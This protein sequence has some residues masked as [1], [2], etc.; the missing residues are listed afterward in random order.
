MQLHSL[1]L[2]SE[3]HRD[4]GHRRYCCRATDAWF[5][6]MH[7]DGASWSDA[8]CIDAD[9]AFQQMIAAATS[10]SEDAAASTVSGAL[11]QILKI[12]NVTSNTH[13]GEFPGPMCSPLCTK[14]I[15]R[16]RQHAY[17]VTEKSDGIRVVVVSL[18]V[19]DFPQ[20]ECEE[21]EEG[22]W[23]FSHLAAV[24]ALE[25][26]RQDLWAGTHDKGTSSSAVMVMLLG[27]QVTL[28]SATTSVEDSQLDETY[29]VIA[30]VEG[31][32]SVA[33]VVRRR[34][35]G[36][37]FAY[38]VDRS[39]NAAYLFLDNHTSTGYQT[40]VLD[41][42]LMC[43]RSP[44]ATHKVVH[45]DVT[46]ATDARL[47]LGAFDLFCF[48]PS[49][50]GQE[51]KLTDSTMM[52]RYEFLKRVIA[53]CAVAPSPKDEGT[54]CLEGRVTWYAKPMWRVEDIG[55]CLSKLSY[56][57]EH[58][59]FLFDGPYGQTENDGLIFTPD[60]FPI[61]V[62]SSSVQLK[63]KWRHLLS[64]DWL[65]SAS[66]KLPD[67]YTVSLFFM[68]K[69]YGHRED[70]IG[71]WRL[72]KPMCI[73]NPRG[74][75]IP[76]DAAVVAECAYD[77]A[78]QQWYIQRLR[79]D[80]RGANSIMTAIS[81]YESLVE[82]ISLPRLLR[83]LQAEVDVGQKEGAAARLAA[84]LEE[85]VLADVSTGAPSQHTLSDSGPHAVDVAQAGKCVTASMTLR[86]IRESRGNSELYLT[87]YTNNT[88][89]AVKF[90][91]PFPLRKIKDCVGLGYDPATAATSVP[92]LE[93]ALYIQLGNA[94]G[95]YAWSD[96]VVDA[97]YNGET[98]CWEL[99]HLSPRGNNKEALFDNVIE[100]LDWLLRHSGSAELE[101]LLQ[102]KRDKPLVVATVH[103]SE[104][105][106]QTSRHY[107]AV[108]KEL[109]H[110]ERSDLRR[111]NN[112]VKSLL[113]TTSAAAVRKTLK[114]PAKLHTVD[115]CCGRGGDLLK[116]QHLHPA[117]VF[118]T[119]ASVECVAEA[120]ARYST[121]EGQSLK[122]SNGKQKG[123]RAF[124]TVHDAFDT[125]SGLRNDLLKH[126]PFQLTSCQFSMHYGCR[127][128]ESI[129]YF[130]R[131]VADSLALRGRFVGTTVSDAE[132]LARAK[133]RGAS[134]G[135][136]VYRVH[137]PETAFAQLQAVDFEPS[138]LAFGVPYSTTVERSV[139]DMKEYVVPW[140]SFVEL[141]AAH[142]LRLLLEDNFLHF[143]A[144][145]RETMEGQAL[146]AEMQRKRGHNGEVAEIPLSSEEM[147]AVQ[148]YRL[149]V[150]EKT[151]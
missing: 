143:C 110:A 82:N 41:G 92:S 35:G 114:D 96:F 49:G 55:V 57:S 66:D 17:T 64:I 42:E 50:G 135:N 72:R 106:Q 13:L 133:A 34:C 20:W 147:E 48:T 43:V 67:V 39:M 22:S 53:A 134:Y 136:N 14:D 97:F 139:Q 10:S 112:W 123:F 124:F 5:R 6:C 63:W 144:Q 148:L 54:C 113:I 26:A 119:D 115:L 51:V 145:H 25:K 101:P 120:A 116:W 75:E 77:F 111:F 32:A 127:S 68:K 94:G 141:C 103:K 52:E 40:F 70:V 130:V 45:D 16:L 140:K 76:V 81:V 30:E 118:M 19:A 138:R 60:V 84:A 1:E 74:L 146:L 7:G 149:F 18:W 46:P 62:G 59:C 21:G 44:T 88:N 128:A 47:L 9:A 109:A 33:F 99:I 117:F 107:G 12:A 132:L 2:L 80:K 83:L 121:S 91:L 89:K 37:H 98:G 69:N 125:A 100:H 151:E 27:R 150:F 23:D 28:Q 102:R 65:L 15:P 38:A 131:A 78:R 90:P 3:V 73:K 137:F 108:A 24:I 4:E 105:T 93:E 86:A 8:Q 29:T 126:G 122:C 79:P 71:H 58:H 104:A 36:R 61:S 129:R 95:C 56:S 11:H 142:R 85:A 31:A 87:V